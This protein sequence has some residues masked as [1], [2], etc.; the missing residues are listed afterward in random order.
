MAYQIQSGDTLWG[1]AQKQFG[2]TSASD[3][4]AKIDELVEINGIEDKNLIFA[5]DTLKL[6]ADKVEL[7][8]NKTENTTAKDTKDEPTIADN[9]NQWLNDHGAALDDFNT[10][11]SEINKYATNLKDNGNLTEEN[12]SSIKELANVA[13][14]AYDEQAL[15]IGNFNFISSNVNLYDEN[16]KFDSDTYFKE[17]N[18][19]AQALYNS[20]KSNNE[21]GVSY[22]EYYKAELG[23][24][25]GIELTEETENY[26][27]AGFIMLD[28][29]QDEK[30][31][32]EEIQSIYSTLDISDENGTFDGV[33]TFDAVSSALNI[34]DDIREGALS[35]IEYIRESVNKQDKEEEKEAA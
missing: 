9:Y 23:R 16:G 27:K 29:N 26:I 11:V 15:A 8:T 14:G 21:D 1:I 28:L 3:I 17:G 10:A 7:S 31:D 12:I 18:E 32:T 25:N 2:L 24:M 5:G 22:D 6:E 13:S 20:W 34:F 30:I 33:L 19:F 35:L 4:N